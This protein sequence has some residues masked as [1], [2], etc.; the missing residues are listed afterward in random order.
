MELICENIMRDKG[1]VCISHVGSR[2]TCSPAPVGTDL[3]VLVLATNVENVGRYLS[4]VGF[5]LDGSRPTDARSIS[6]DCRFESFSKNGVNYIITESQDF[7]MRFMAATSVAKRLNLLAKDD[8]IALF[9]AV[10]YG[11]AAR[12]GATP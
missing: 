1:A 5:A 4:S 2:V 11:N 12:Q 3:D 10:L 8:R 9:Q 7:Y 6:P